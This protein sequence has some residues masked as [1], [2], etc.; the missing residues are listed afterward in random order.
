M[1][2]TEFYLEVLALEAEGLVAPGTADQ[3]LP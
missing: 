2:E 3:Y 1:D